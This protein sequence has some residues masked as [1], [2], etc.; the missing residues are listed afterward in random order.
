MSQITLTTSEAGALAHAA[1]LMRDVLVDA[2][3][4]LDVCSSPL[5]IG[6]AKLLAALERQQPVMLP[7][8]DAAALLAHA[9]RSIVTLRVALRL[10]TSPALQPPYLATGR[11]ASWRVSQ[12]VD[13]N[14]ALA[15]AAIAAADPWA[16]PALRDFGDQIV[17]LDDDHNQKGSA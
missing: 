6:H 7:L 8:E 15:D 10:V 2:H 11:S 3:I 9:E 5:G 13:A 16:L 12:A 1:E 17:A 14:R 4:D